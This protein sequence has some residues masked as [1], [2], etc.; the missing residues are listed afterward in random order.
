MSGERARLTLADV[1][2]FPRPGMAI[3][4]RVAFTPDGDAVT[5][6]HSES[7]SLVRALWEYTIESGERR[8]LAGPRGEGEPLS[9]EEELRRERTR[10]RE[11]GVTDY[12]FAREASERT[13]LIPGGAL[14]RVQVGEGAMRE[15]PGTEGALDARIDPTGQRVSFAREGELFVVD[16]DGGDPRQ[17]S[18]GAED[19]L[20]NGV[21][22]YIAAEELERT[23][24]H[25]WSPQSDRI[26]YV[27]ADSRH[28]PNYAIVHQGKDEVD[29]E[30]H[31]YP[32]AGE[33]NGFVELAVVDVETGSTVW[34][35]L[36]AEKDFY[37]SRVQWRPD[38][39]LTAQVLSRDQ[40]TIS[41]L[42][43]DAAGAE[44][45]LIEETGDPW[46]NVDQGSRFL[47][48]GE[49]LWSSERDGFRHLY[50]HDADG[51]LLRQLTSGEWVVTRVVGVD[52]EGRL[53]YFMATAE[54]PRE[55][56]LYRVSLDGGEIERLTVEPGWHDCALSPSGDAFIDTWSSPEAA[57]VVRL[58]SL[59]NGATVSLHDNERLSAASLGLS[60]P[61]FLTLPAEDGTELHASIYKPDPLEAG[62]R[63]PVV[64]A[65]YGGPHAQLVTESWG[66]T[67]D[68]RAQYL[69]QQGYVVFRLDNRGSAN[70]GLAFE[71]HLH[72]RMGTVEV[73]DQVAGVRFLQS[74]PYVDG[75]RIGVYGWS[76]GGY[77][78]CLCLMRA[79]E[80]FK[81]GVAGAPVTHWDGYDTG[82]TERYMS[83]PGDNEAGYHEGSVLAHVEGL[84]GKLLLVHGGIDENVH[85]RHTAR[86]ITAL[87]AAQKSYDLLLLPEERHMPRDAK[88]LEYQERRL[89]GFFEEHL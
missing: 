60:P 30:N 71:A 36:G 33:A 19:G 37:L 64:V 76:Y 4:G 87:T 78:T 5:Y 54:S 12:R 63:Y 28:I 8:V 69:A 32:F 53:A 21:A 62:R 73:E 29:V 59:G 44:T 38:G 18:S 9:R 67:V 82:Y 43:F 48:S 22:D 81:V 79:P 42:A 47:E 49:I 58:H 56:Q 51:S 89:V 24:G 13:L 15:L 70:R 1:A 7:G 26:A 86:L 75:E 11:L 52:E 80:M 72:R 85:F 27:R 31:R 40:T 45:T 74:S 46:I 3:P 34:M 66:A 77:M 41:L 35:E 68:L 14:L 17:L 2:R 83:T 57:P 50:V 39:V 23:D 84:E 20:T 25:W 61:E 6:L 16:L 88:G 55:R 65:V 10:T